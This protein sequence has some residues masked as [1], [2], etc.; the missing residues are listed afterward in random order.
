MNCP[1]HCIVYKDG[2]GPRGS[3]S[4]KEL[5]LKL[6]EL[7]TVYR[8][9]R[10]GTLHGLFRA[11]GF[12]QD[13]GHVFCTLEQVKDEIASILT[14]IE[15]TFLKFGFRVSHELHES[16]DSQSFSTHPYEIYNTISNNLVDGDGRLLLPLMSSSATNIQDLASL[17]ITSNAEQQKD[18]ED[19][20]SPFKRPTEGSVSFS[21]STRPLEEDEHKDGTDQHVEKVYKNSIGDDRTWELATSSLQRGLEALNLPFEVEEGE[22]AFYGP[23][24]DVHIT[25]NLGRKWQCSTIQCDFSLPEKFDLWVHRGDKEGEDAFERPILLHR[26]I[27]GSIERFM[28]I[29]V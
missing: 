10:T 21:L 22:G 15:R 19:T 23:K 24:I 7:G 26:A 8:Y 5:P 25:D 27:F 13:D 18:H 2:D 29:L 16:S 1:F 3:R 20:E 12:T 6:C 14:L 4:Y 9:E 17:V 11:R 28:G